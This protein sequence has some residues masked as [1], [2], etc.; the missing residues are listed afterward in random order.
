M[1][2]SP[3]VTARSAAAVPGLRGYLSR[4]C[5][6]EALAGVYQDS[7][8]VRLFLKFRHFHDLRWGVGHDV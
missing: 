2:T 7:G 1:V 3:Q 4:N 8:V 5:I 6:R